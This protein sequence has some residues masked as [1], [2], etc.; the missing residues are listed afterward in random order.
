MKT[1]QFVPFLEV[2]DI[3]GGTQPPKSTFVDEPTDGYVRLLQIQDFKT[4]KKAVFVPDKQTLKKC[5]KNDIMIARYGASLGKIL[6]GLEGAYNVALVKTIPD[7]ERLDRA[8]F[9]HFLRADA[10]QSFILNLGGRAA[11]AGFNK[12]DLERIKIPLPPLEEQKRIAGILDQADA[13]RRLRTR[14]LD[15]LNTLGQAIFHEMFETRATSFWQIPTKLSDATSKITD[16]THHSPP[17]VNEG[18]PYITAKHLK[19][20][21]LRF[22]NKPWFISPEDHSSIYSRCNPEKGDVLYIKDG[23]TTGLAA[24]NRYEFEFSMLSSLALLKPNHNLCLPEYL[25]FWLN[26]DLFKSYALRSMSGAGITRL[27]LKKIK[28]MPI[29]LPA[30]QEQREFVERIFRLEAQANIVSEQTEKLNSLFASLQH[31]A[32]RGEL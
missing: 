27:T 23:A 28:D 20:E 12:A 6:F 14:A 11:Q 21:G 19:R 18:I 5:S 10:F 25:C 17:I 4:D 8:Y 31:R 24:V 1:A 26:S 2:C 29:I 9:S 16:G 32:F 3:Q 7:L 22:E 30:I 15:K 13:L